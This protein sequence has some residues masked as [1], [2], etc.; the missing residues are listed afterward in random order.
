MCGNCY[1]CDIWNFFF[2]FFQIH[3]LQTFSKLKKIS[4][5]FA[6]VSEHPAHY[7]QFSKKCHFCRGGGEVWGCIFWIWKI[8]KFAWNLLKYMCLYFFH[9]F[10]THRVTVSLRYVYIQWG[11]KSINTHNFLLFITLLV[12]LDAWNFD[13]I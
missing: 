11:D 10:E 1:C 12:H 4:Y 13:R 6:H 5:I 9:I 8:Q 2:R 7:E 3:T